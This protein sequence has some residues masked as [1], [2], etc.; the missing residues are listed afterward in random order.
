MT[1]QQQGTTVYL[2]T[3]PPHTT[4][5]IPCIQLSQPASSCHV[6][7]ACPLSHRTVSP[8][9][10]DS[11]HHYQDQISLTWD[12]PKTEFLNQ[13]HNNN[14]CSHLLY[15]KF[16]VT[17]REGRYLKSSSWK[18]IFSSFLHFVFRTRAERRLA[19]SPL[20]STTRFLFGA[21]LTLSVRDTSIAVTVKDVFKDV[22]L[23]IRQYYI[24]CC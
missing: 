22:T 5:Q 10:S 16:R 17:Y 13:K 2:R 24:N 15:T 23:N 12:K 19:V 7:S 21:F 20:S 9:Y 6:E 8:Y 18:S 3:Y 4:Y 14:V 11:H 1:K